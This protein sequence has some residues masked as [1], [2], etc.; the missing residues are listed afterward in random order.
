[1]KVFL[2]PN[3][4]QIN[5]IPIINSLFI[6]IILYLHHGSYV[7]NYFL[8]FSDLGVNLLLQ[9]FA[10]GGFFSFPV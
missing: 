3:D 6:S 1:M 5:F 10:V 9:K 7:N 4:S 2:K 8:V